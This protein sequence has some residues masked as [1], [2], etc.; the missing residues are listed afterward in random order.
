M[1]QVAHLGELRRQPLTVTL[2]SRRGQAWNIFEHHGGGT[3]LI[4]DAQGFGKKISL[5]ITAQLLASDRKR[6][7]W[8]ATSEELDTAKVAAINVPDIGLDNAPLRA[9]QAQRRA[10]SRIDFDGGGAREPR[11]LKAQRL[12]ATTGAKFNYRQPHS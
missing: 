5:V 10:G 3:R 8:N 9:V 1:R 2:E 7:A 6:R 12:S 4:D 11:R